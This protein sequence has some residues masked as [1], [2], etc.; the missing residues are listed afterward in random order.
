MK[1]RRFLIV[2]TVAVLILGLNSGTGAVA[3]GAALEPTSA[4]TE[5][6]PES[7]QYAGG[8]QGLAEYSAPSDIPAD[9]LTAVQE[10][11]LRSEYYVT[12]QDKTHLPDVP[13]A[14]QA[15][16]RAHGFRTYFT[17]AGIHVIPRS[18]SA[19]GWQ[20]D[21]SLVGYGTP[22]A[23]VPM[24]PAELRTDDGLVAFRHEGLY[25][26]Y[27][28]SEAGLSHT[29]LIQS[30]PDADA[31]ELGLALRLSG[32]LVPAVAAGGQAVEFTA[33]SGDRVPQYGSLRA[34]D[35]AGRPLA[36]QLELLEGEAIR[37]SIDDSRAVYP[38][39]V[40]LAITGMSTTP[41]WSYVGGQVNE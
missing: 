4:H 8:T 21:L 37:I 40:D 26:S 28:N 36:A 27:L 35:S 11:I 3:E 16:N 9:W 22:G 2:A 31:S 25:Q 14:Y 7:L 12:W 1:T 19:R 38:V 24:A 20:L 6:E 39:T 15:A 33:A 41:D 10:E 32:D 29:I 17:P 18:E 23:L 13:Q 34:T 5:G 30:D